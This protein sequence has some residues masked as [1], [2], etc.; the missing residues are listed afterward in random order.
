MRVYK[1]KT[2][3]DDFIGH[4]KIDRG[5]LVEEDRKEEKC[6]IELANQNCRVMLGDDEKAGLSLKVRK[7]KKDYKGLSRV[8]LKDA[9][10]DML[11]KK[12]NIGAR[13]QIDNEI[14]IGTENKTKNLNIAANA[15]SFTGKD[16]IKVN[17]SKI[18]IG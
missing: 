12:L 17:G 15:V 9:S 2:V 11:S 8:D 4:I 6:E 1:D 16:R 7:D 10:L 14:N 3:G 13:S 5:I 18:L